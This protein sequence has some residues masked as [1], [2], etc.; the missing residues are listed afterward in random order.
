MKVISKQ[1]N[2]EYN[3]KPLSP[4]FNANIIVTSAARSEIEESMHYFYDNCSR[5][6]RRRFGGFSLNNF[7][8]L[9]KKATTNVQGTI[10]LHVGKKFDQLKLIYKEPFKENKIKRR[11]RR[12]FTLSMNPLKL[13]PDAKYDNGVLCSDAVINL[14]IKFSNKLT[15][16]KIEH[17]NNP[18][19]KII[20]SFMDNMVQEKPSVIIKAIPKENPFKDLPLQPHPYLVSLSP[21][22]F[23]S[24]L[25]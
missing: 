9:L 22:K 4:A 25:N 23:R 20:K 19:L 21:E 13:R 10:E 14:L 1:N 16:K 11:K 17:K 18:F 3:K 5:G 24:L 2:N 7:I 8:N 15:S 6:K 12:R